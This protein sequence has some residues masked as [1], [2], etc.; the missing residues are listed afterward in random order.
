[1][2]RRNLDDMAF[3]REQLSFEEE[4]YLRAH[5]WRHTSSDNPCCLWL[6]EIWWNG[7]V[8]AVTRDVALKMQREIEDSLSWVLSCIGARLCTR[9]LDDG[10]AVLATD[11]EFCAGCH[12]FLGESQDER[13]AS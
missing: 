12:D 3:D 7:R 10:N 6:W 2:A 1:M 8:L 4:A 11:G 9:C 13:N 5:G